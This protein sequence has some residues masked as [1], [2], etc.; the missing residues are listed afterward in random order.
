MLAAWL[1]SN[2][3]IAGTVTGLGVV[4]LIEARMRGGI[5]QMIAGGALAIIGLGLLGQW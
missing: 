2:T 4:L 5:G 3:V 1:D